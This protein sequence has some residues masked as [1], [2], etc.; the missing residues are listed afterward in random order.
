VNLFALVKDPQS[1]VRRLSV[2]QSLNQQITKLFEDQ[3]NA[4][5]GDDPEFVPFDGN[6]TPDEGEFLEIANFD[7]PAAL[8]S[9]AKSPIDCPAFVANDTGLAT[10]RGL[11]L[12]EMKG[13]EPYVLIQRFDQRRAITS[14]GLTLWHSHKT[15]QKLEGVGLTLDDRLTAII[16]GPRLIF[17]SFFAVRPLFDM[18]NYFTEATDSDLKK[19]QG[20]SRIAL[21]DGVK[22]TDLADS[23]VR[24]R[25]SIID[26]SGVLD[27]LTPSQLSNA[28]TRYKVAV[29]VQ[30]IGNTPKIVLPS[31]KKALKTLL[32]FL[33][34]DLLE[35]PLSDTKFLTNSKRPI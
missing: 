5:L 27:R 32:H 14:H 20:H 13:T 15:F 8:L 16:D 21:P 6:Y 34:E 31:D 30:R 23:W 9:A 7:T 19:F 28:A 24:R 22:L 35:S 4:F 1:N 17:R 29:N 33:A 26:E 18:T 3:A 10:L 11:A 25:I 2:A 12:A